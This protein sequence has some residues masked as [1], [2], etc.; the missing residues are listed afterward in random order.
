MK[1]PFLFRVCTT[2]ILCVSCV[3]AEPDGSHRMHQFATQW[4]EQDWVQQHGD[5]GYMRRT[6]DAG[7]RARMLA[8]QEFVRQGEAAVPTLLESLRS[9]SSAQR[10]LAAQALGYLAPSIPIEPLRKAAS[11][12]DDA[13][14]RLYAVDALGMKGVSSDEVDWSALKENEKNRDA[15]KHIGY[16]KLRDGELVKPAIV[17]KLRDW[18]ADAIDTA[19][20]GNPAPDFELASAT[21]ETIRLSQYRD[22]K[23]VVLVFIY[24][25]T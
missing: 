13:A 5:R 7:W 11:D 20:V 4:N 18:N 3:A 21:G 15:I 19:I 22:K 12:D 23:A 25:D 14:V 6:G 17:A 16:A 2:T 9:D 10:I 24:G 1:I 8:L